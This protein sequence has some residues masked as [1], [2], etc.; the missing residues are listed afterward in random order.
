MSGPCWP[1][2]SS[3]SGSCSAARTERPA[4]TSGPAGADPLEAMVG[5]GTS[6]V[7]PADPAAGPAAAVGPPR[8]RRGRGR[9]PA[10]HRAGPAGAQAGRPRDRPGRPWPATARWTSTGPRRRPGWSRSPT[11]GWC[12]GS[13]WGCAPTRTRWALAARLDGLRRGRPA[14]LHG[15][16]LRLPDLAAGVPDPRPALTGSALPRTEPRRVTRDAR[17]HV[18]GLRGCDDLGLAAV[19]LTVVGCSGSFPGPESAASCYL[20][21]ADRRRR[22]ASG[23]SCSTSAAARSGHCSGYTSLYAVDAVLLSHLHPDHCL[24]L[25]G[26]YVALKYRPGGPAPARCRST[27]RAAPGSGC[28]SPTTGC[29][30]RA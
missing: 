5:I 29:P 17:C 28:G 11:S 12:W 10:L 20:V 21:E 8:G 27:A 2:C 18:A 24:D 23:G 14:G 13:G 15:R 3:R 9:V 30:S 19:R 25:T 16:D 22:P 26:M 6:T 7:E 1:I 4:A